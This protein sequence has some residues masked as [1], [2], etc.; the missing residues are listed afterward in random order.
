MTGTLRTDQKAEPLGA[1]APS[2]AFDMPARVER[3]RRL[4]EEEAVDCVLVND[5]VSARWVTGFTGSS[6]V[7]LVS[8]DEVVL[9]TDGR[10]ADQAPMEIEAAGLDARVVISTSPLDEL[11]S[12][13][14]DRRVGVE[15]EHL[16]WADHR[17]YSE[18]IDGEITG[19]GRSLLM[20]RAVKDAGERDRI[21]KAAAIA[22]A[23]LEGV[24][25]RLEGASEREVAA[26]LDHT[27]RRLGAAGS[28][29]ETIVASGPN[30]ALPHARPTDRV[31]A[32]G[33]LVIIDV[34]ALY[35]GYRS[36]MT[37]TFVVGAPTPTQ[38]K[39]LDVVAEAQSRGV[40]ALRA[41]IDARAVDAACRDLIAAEGLGDRF[42]HGTGHGVGLDIHEHPRVSSRSTDVIEVGM[43]VTVEPG[44]YVP[45]E[46]GVRWEDLH[47]VT[48]EGAV[49]LGESPKARVLG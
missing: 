44:V 37:R 35:D 9:F 40:E 6:G 2:A 14:G 34:G 46:G 1:G 24:A 36:D 29:Y 47:L 43:L 3:V 13:V 30:S 5:L 32:E 33:D 38:Q 28:A 16:S 11:P 17:R 7:A 15:A 23:A 25:S 19:L 22:D 42:T 41:G 48:A 4:S 18:A 8:H 45:G 12:I 26:E 27:M 39:W 20:L 21:S 10:Y 49:A 31:I